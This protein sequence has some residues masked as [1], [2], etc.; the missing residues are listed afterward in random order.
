MRAR[1]QLAIGELE[2]GGERRGLGPLGV[3]EA[4]VHGEARQ[5][6]VAGLTGTGFQHLKLGP[7]RLG[8]HVVGRDGRDAAPVVDARFE[9]TREVGVREV[10]R[11]LQAH[12]VGQDQPR[13]RERP[14]VLVE[15][16]LGRVDHLGAGLGAEVLDD[17]LLE[18][19]VLGVQL[20]QRQQRLDLFAASLADADQDARRGWDLVRAHPAQR[21]EAHRGLLIGRAVVRHA[22]LAQP[23]ARRLEHDPL[24]RRPRTRGRQFCVAEDAGVGVGQQAGLGEHPLHAVH[25]IGDGRLEAELR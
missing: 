18:M 17:H 14:Q 24:A 25:E 20:A 15:R 8:I 7:R 16:R 19:A 12:L 22:L 10:R 11:R 21:V 4:R 6:R 23:S 13:H 2:C 9:Q 3:E 1:S 5:Q